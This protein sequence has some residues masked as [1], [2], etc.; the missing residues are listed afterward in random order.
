MQISQLATILNECERGTFPSQPIPNPR[1]QNSNSN[2]AYV[3]QDSNV[4]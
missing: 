1:N 2:Q 4:N 3:V